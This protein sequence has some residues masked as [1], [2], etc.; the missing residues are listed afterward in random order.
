MRSCVYVGVE[1]AGRGG[2]GVELTRMRLTAVMGTTA[3]LKVLRAMNGEGGAHPR[4]G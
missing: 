1:F 2:C 4:S 3:L